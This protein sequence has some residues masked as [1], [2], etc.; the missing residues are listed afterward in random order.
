MNVLHLD[1]GGVVGWAIGDWSVRV[2]LGVEGR[3]SKKFAGRK[4]NFAV[5]LFSE[6]RARMHVSQV[7]A[8]SPT[9]LARAS[10]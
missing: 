9:Y 10:T 4:S 8:T 2:S 1:V 3:I 5:G 7:G 6:G